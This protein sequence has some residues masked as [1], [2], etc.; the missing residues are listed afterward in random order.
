MIKK[1]NVRKTYSVEYKLLAVKKHLEDGVSC[2]RV[3][4]EFK[5]HEQ[6]IIKWC[7]KYRELRIEALEEQ[8]VS[9]K[10]SSKGH[11]ELKSF[12]KR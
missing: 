11:L 7:K 1:C 6:M 10:G 9:F 8:R 3:A 5:I 4:E 2:R 12:Q